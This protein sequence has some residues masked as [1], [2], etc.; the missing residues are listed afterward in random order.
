MP[1]EL[2]SSAKRFP[3][4]SLILF[5]SENKDSQALYGDTLS[6]RRVGKSTRKVGGTAH[7]N[8]QCVLPQNWCGTQPKSIVT[9]TE[10]KAAVNSGVTENIMTP[11]Q[12]QGLAP[13]VDLTKS[14]SQI[15]GSLEP[16]ALLR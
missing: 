12:S 14:V 16:W 2:E 5:I 1:A 6:N 10:L 7:D 9:C 13:K 3:S 15:L 4:E 11:L 8:S